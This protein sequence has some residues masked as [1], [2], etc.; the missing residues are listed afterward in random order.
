MSYS[1]FNSRLVAVIPNWKLLRCRFP[2]TPRWARLNMPTAGSVILISGRPHSMTAAGGSGLLMV[3]I[4]DIVYNPGSAVI[5]DD[6][7][8]SPSSRRLQVKKRTSGDL[9]LS[10]VTCKYMT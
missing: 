5:M 7:Q 6:I 4:E 8:T 2:A 9:D 10:N 1:F 3:T